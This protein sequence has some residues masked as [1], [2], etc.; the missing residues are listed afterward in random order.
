MLTFRHAT[1]DDAALLTELNQQLIQDEGH[2]NRMTFAELEGRMRTWLKTDYQ[3]VLFE[4][5]AEIVAYAVYRP[6]QG[7]TYLRQFF[8]KRQ[9]RRQGIG[10]AAMRL[11]LHKIIAP[12]ARV[13]L[14]VLVD[15][16]PARQFWRSIG[17]KDYAL[18]LE[19]TQQNER[20]LDAGSPPA[21]APDK[22][23]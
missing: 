19:W 18:T 8:V 12:G 14:D 3:A 6:E 17:F 7:A 16:S 1:L 9:R 2:R 23:P 15:N 4:Q 10:R 13:Y 11:L 22:T 5:A 20:S 21:L